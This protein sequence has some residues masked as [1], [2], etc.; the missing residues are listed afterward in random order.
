MKRYFLV[1]GLALALMANLTGTLQAEEK[2]L[3]MGLIPA[4]DPKAMIEQIKPMK[5]WMEKSLGRCITL[6]TASDYTGVIEAMRAKKVDFAW[7]GPFSYTMA[8]DRA[9]AEAFAVGIDPKG[10]STYRSYL[11]ATPETA[12]KLGISTPLEGEAG[13]REIF[14]KIKSL[15]EKITFT[16]TDPAS[17]SG[18]AVPRYFMWKVGMDPEKVFRKVGFSGTHDAAELM[19]KNQT[20]DMCSDNDMTNPAM[21]AA[22]KISPQTNIIIWQSIPLPG[23]P[24]AYRADLPEDIKAGLQ[25]AITTV[26]ENANKVTAFGNITGW[27]LVNDSDYNLI[28]EVKKVIDG[29]K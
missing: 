24:V 5:A 17:T 29:L 20:V 26:P 2:C 18:Y 9:G 8:H 6:F 1:I 4:E 28:K 10:K 21:V 25:K 15:P 27:K 3:V 22:G 14:E 23:S 13:M 11:V 16:F 19:V 12:G 7:F